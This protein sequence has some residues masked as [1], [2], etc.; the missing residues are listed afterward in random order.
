MMLKDT[1]SAFENE[2]KLKTDVE[3]KRMSVEV[4]KVMHE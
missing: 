1:S 2:Q 4:R 3:S